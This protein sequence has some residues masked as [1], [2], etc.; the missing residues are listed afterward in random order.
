MT[1]KQKINKLLNDYECKISFEMGGTSYYC[2][3]KK[4]TLFI[5]LMTLKLLCYLVIL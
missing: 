1:Q 2:H 4:L 5:V 3:K